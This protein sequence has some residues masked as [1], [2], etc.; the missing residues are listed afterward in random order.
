MDRRLST[1]LFLLAACFIVSL[2]GRDVFA[3][4]RDP[5]SFSRNTIS[6]LNSVLALQPNDGTLVLAANDTVQFTMSVNAQAPPPNILSAPYIAVSSEAMTGTA[7]A[8]AY[9]LYVNKNGQGLWRLDQVIAK[10]ENG[11]IIWGSNNSPILLANQSNL[12]ATA[13]NRFTVSQGTL[14]LMQGSSITLQGTA[15]QVQFIMGQGTTLNARGPWAYSTINADGD[16]AGPRADNFINAANIQLQNNV[17]LGFDLTNY[18]AGQPILNLQGNVTLSDPANNGKLNLLGFTTSG[19]GTVDGVT[20]QLLQYNYTGTAPNANEIPT[21]SPTYATPPIRAYYIDGSNNSVNVNPIPAGSLTYPGNFEVQ[22]R[23]QGWDAVQTASRGRLQGTL[24]QNVPEAAAGGQINININNFKSYVGEVTWTGNANNN[25]WDATSQNWSG[26]IGNYGSTN[27]FLHGDVVRFGT[28]GLGNITVQNGGVQIGDFGNSNGKAGLG[29]I[30]NAG[31][32]E[33][34]NEN[35]SLIG[36][37]GAGS[38]YITTL[39]ENLPTKTSVTFNSANSYWGGTTVNSAYLKLGNTGGVGTGSLHLENTAQLTFETS[40]QNDLFF[41]AISTTN[42]TKIFKDN[43]NTLTIYGTVSGSADTTVRDGT[44]QKNIGQGV[45]TVFKG[46]VYDT[47]D[48]DR[49]IAGLSDRLASD[50]SSEPDSPDARVELHNYKLYINVTGSEYVFSGQIIGTGAQVTK[51]GPGTQVFANVNNTYSGGTNISAGTLVGRHVFD[52]V[53]DTNTNTNTVDPLHTITFRPFGTGTINIGKENSDSVKN[54]INNIDENALLQFH[55]TRDIVGD[56]DAIPPIY[57]LELYDPNK[58]YDPADSSTYQFIATVDNTITGTGSLELRGESLYSSSTDGSTEIL[59]L[60]AND[61][62]Y[63]GKTLIN[64]GKIRIASVHSTGKTGEVAIAGNSNNP[65]FNSALQFKVTDS[66]K[67]NPYDRIITGKG[68]IEI[69]AGTN[70]KNTIVFVRGSNEDQ[71]DKFSNYTGQTLVEEF[72][73]LHL[74]DV[75]ATGQ[76]NIVDLKMNTSDLYLDFTSLTNDRGQEID[77][78]YN[79]YIHGDGNLTKTDKGTAVLELEQRAVLRPNDYTGTTTVAD[80]ILKL[81]YAEATGASDAIDEQRVE[82]KQDSEGTGILELAFDGDYKKGIKGQGILAKSEIGTISYLQ[83]KSTY[84]GGT[85]IYGG[86]LS[87]SDLD[88]DT[89]G[90]LGSGG[91]QFKR[92]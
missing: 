21:G 29:M 90:N 13:D 67:T 9:N 18:A 62:T 16:P 28:A 45:L 83:G 50:D 6:G 22:V 81:K 42:G 65:L 61:S 12:W 43:D 49:N 46:A 36:I 70:L 89:A 77:Q 68:N 58:T 25:R 4:Q 86:T 40:V 1:L 88:E 66:L 85:Y 74:L 75:H 32:Y 76:T 69:L 38:V 71:P 64:S 82:V 7:A 47:L 37:D 53:D 78:V 2:A 72:S 63:T 41:N 15:A 80:G 55:L 33:F 19:S 20:V 84:Q 3:Q 34:T 79:R 11:N 23:G 31:T 30:V 60:T 35:N 8:L 52:K 51:A 26:Y 54:D 39:A 59:Y 44:L 17:T 91:V 73:E 10:D 27:T 5:H 24:T 14:E 92:G 48:A 57:P 87:Y 56:L